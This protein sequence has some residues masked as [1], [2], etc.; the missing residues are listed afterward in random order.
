MTTINQVTDEMIDAGVIELTKD[1]YN[2]DIYAAPS[3]G[4][5]EK[6]CKFVTKF[7]RD[8][9]AFKTVPSEVVDIVNI[10]N[11]LLEEYAYDPATIS[12]SDIEERAFDLDIRSDTWNKYLA[13]FR[14]LDESIQLVKLGTNLGFKIHKRPFATLHKNINIMSK[15]GN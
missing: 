5:L 2:A 1:S 12:F 10:I 8:N 9:L 15:F 7:R 11:D 4:V 6:F 13:V 14:N 3:R